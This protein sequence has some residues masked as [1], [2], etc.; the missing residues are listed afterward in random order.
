MKHILLITAFTIVTVGIAAQNDVGFT[1]FNWNKLAYNPAYAGS[2]TVLDLAAVYRNQWSGIEGAPTSLNLAGNTSFFKD[3]AGFGI[4]VQSDQIGIT[5][6]QLVS[7]NYAYKIRLDQ[8]TRLS[9]G[10]STALENLEADWS[11]NRPDVAE[12]DALPGGR[13]SVTRANFGAGAYLY[14]DNYFVGLSVPRLLNNSLDRTNPG[15][16]F[17]GNYARTA[18]LMMG[19]MMPLGQNVDFRPTVLL[20]YN[21]AAP[22]D[23]DINLNFLLG[24]MVW[25]GANYRWNDSLAGIV[26][27]E[28]NQQLRL[29]L[30]YDFTTSELQKATSGSFEAMVGY[31]FHCETCQVTN[32]RF[33]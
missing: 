26:Q 32:L 22:L 11:L 18:F 7:L 2:K 10:M 5:K 1:Q 12:D 29:G 33:F 20:S 28:V 27:F 13:N 8:T 25:L 3:R 19:Y 6:N 4:Q 9:L 30:S 24:K 14:S 17:N 23:L 21:R 31:T 15:D 16:M